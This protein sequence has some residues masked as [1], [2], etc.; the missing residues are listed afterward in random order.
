MFK[1]VSIFWAFSF[2]N[3][4]SAS[5]KTIRILLFLQHQPTLLMAYNKEQIQQD[6]PYENFK[7]NR[8]FKCRIRQLRIHLSHKHLSSPR[9]NPFNDSLS[10]T[11][12]LPSVTDQSLV[13]WHE[14]QLQDYP[15]TIHS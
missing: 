9:L 5:S 10:T 12:L 8:S 11:I 1:K 7:L 2:D 3:F 4:N 6:V 13:H 15:K 14:L